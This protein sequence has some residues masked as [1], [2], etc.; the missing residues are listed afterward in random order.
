MRYKT[1]I[2]SLVLYKGK[3]VTFFKLELHVELLLESMQPIC[4]YSFM[5]L[6][7]IILFT[8]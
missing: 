6:C 1:Y 7:I 8:L 3:Y 2:H 5:L 4:M